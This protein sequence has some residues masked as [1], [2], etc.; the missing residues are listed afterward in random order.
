MPTI[1]VIV[2]FYNVE[3]ALFCSCIESILQQTYSDFEIIIVNDGSRSQ[4]DAVL[5]NAVKIDNRVRLINKPNGGVSTARNLGVKEAKG[6]YIAFVDADDVVQ[7]Q[8]LKE[9]LYVIGK[10]NVDFVLGASLLINAKNKNFSI[11]TVQTTE[12]DIKYAVF[13]NNEYDKLIP[14]LIALNRQIRF[15]DGSYINRG[16]VAKLLKIDI[17]RDV[18]FPEDIVI[19]EDLIWNQCVLRKCAHVAVVNRTWYYYLQND[20]SATQIYRKNAFEQT[21]SELFTLYGILDLNNDE[22]YNAFCNRVFEETRNIICKKYLTSKECKKSF[23]TKWRLFLQLK[24]MK[25]WCDITKRYLCTLKKRDNIRKLVLFLLFRSNLLFP[26][27]YVK[28]RIF[29][30]WEDT[31]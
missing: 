14:S 2:P 29:S 12:T 30:T 8:Y 13:N 21:Q 19:G 27:I 22:I 26:V 11:Q 31:L 3:E 7:K 16:P 4:F 20:S 9:A 6:K 28:D 24:K 5:A 15:S 18:N 1:S 23:L 17:A 25:P 10:E